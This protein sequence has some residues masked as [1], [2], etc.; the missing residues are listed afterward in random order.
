[1][2]KESLH[3]M[4]WDLISDI[5]SDEADAA[6]KVAFEDWFRAN[7]KNKNIFEQAQKLWSS[8][9]DLAH[10]H[11]ETTDK[12]WDKVKGITFV[13]SHKKRYTRQILVW[14]ASA[15]ASLLL[16]LLLGKQILFPERITILTE[17]ELVSDYRLPDESIVDLNSESKLSY[18]KGF[19]GKNRELWLNGE[20]FFDVKK[21]RH[22][23]FIIHTQQGDFKVLGTSFN[24][25]SYPSDSLL[26]LSVKT[27]VVEFSPKELNGSI[28]V[29]EGEEIH[30]NKSRKKILKRVQFNHNYIAWKTGVLSFDNLELSKVAQR[31]EA[32][33]KV[34][35]EFESDEINNLKFTASFE[36]QEIEKIAKVIALTFELN[37]NINKKHIRFS[38]AQL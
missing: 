6:Q 36:N 10:C 7:E 13:K 14:S 3:S 23:A 28:K 19:A 29:K 25:R 15:A 37:I 1:M 33:Y 34:Q 21:M 26:S 35:I 20:A 31:L 27:G 5:L 8:T 32:I 22:K 9:G 2:K 11:S 18:I 24:I 12:A 16:L 17:L 30:F 38:Q 4:D